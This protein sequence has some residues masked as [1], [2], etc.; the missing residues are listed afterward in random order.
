VN[1]SNGEYRGLPLGGEVAI[2]L[3]ERLL[4]TPTPDI[5]KLMREIRHLV[6]AA[7]RPLREQ[8]KDLVRLRLHDLA[9]VSLH[10]QFTGDNEYLMS[11]LRSILPDEQCEPSRLLHTLARLP[12][13]LLV[14]TNYDRLMERALEHAGKRPL[15]VAPPRTSKEQA[16]LQEELVRHSGPVLYKIHG[17]FGDQVIPR[18]PRGEPPPVIISEEDYIEF[19]TLAPVRSHAVPRQIE[20]KLTRGVLLFLGY[21]LEDWDFRTIYKGIVEKLS[22]DMRRR[23]FAIQKSP[24]QFWVDFWA[25][26]RV[27][28]YDIDLYE[29]AAQLEERYAAASEV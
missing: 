20:E 5:D 26:K 29:F 19:L 16:A 8:Y 25:S 9:R 1:V 2:R 22:F 28:I 21:G 10:V 17:S 24:S 27:T 11:L 15:V 23:S 14:T 4:G 13:E 6:E 12:L 3:L 7:P 18:G